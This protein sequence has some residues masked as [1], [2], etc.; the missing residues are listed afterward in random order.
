MDPDG[1]RMDKAVADIIP[2]RSSQVWVDLMAGDGPVAL[3]DDW[4]RLSN[5]S[6]VEG[7]PATATAEKGQLYAEEELT[8]LLEF[9]TEFR[10]MPTLP[11]RNYTALG[12]DPNP[13]YR[14]AVDTQ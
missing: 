14:N 10:S 7:D 11:R 2:Q 5:G 1:V 13:Y 9:C 6:G 8:N 3:I 12:D 4:S